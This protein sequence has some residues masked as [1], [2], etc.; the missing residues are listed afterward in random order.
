MPKKFHAVLLNAAKRECVASK[1][2]HNYVF[3]K[4]SSKISARQPWTALLAVTMMNSDAKI[5]YNVRAGQHAH[6]NMRWC[7]C[8]SPSPCFCACTNKRPR[9][10]GYNPGKPRPTPHPPPHTI[11]LATTMY[12]RPLIK[13]KAYA[14]VLLQSPKRCGHNYVVGLR[15][16]AVRRGGG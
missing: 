7:T 3:R 15:F 10:S 8:T 9:L 13:D 4:P 16:E 11:Y 2:G 5:Y 14:L 1:G 12:S 6:D